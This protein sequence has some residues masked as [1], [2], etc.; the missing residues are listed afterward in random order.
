MAAAGSTE[1]AKVREAMMGLDFQG[2]SKQV[3]FAPNGDSGSDY[4][5]FKVVDGKF[6]PFWNPKT[7]EAF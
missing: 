6:V 4:I 2:A 3:K 5:I 7:G 1:P